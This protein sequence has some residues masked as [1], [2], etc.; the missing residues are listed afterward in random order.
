M[1]AARPASVAVV[2]RP[3][4][5]IAALQFARIAQVAVRQMHAAHPIDEGAQIRQDAPIEHAGDRIAQGRVT[6]RAEV[7]RARVA[8][9][10]AVERGILAT[11]AKGRLEVLR[12]LLAPL[13]RQALGELPLA[14]GTETVAPACAGV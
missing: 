4:A 2:L 5:C 8:A 3:R 11:D 13:A 7:V 6:V 9:R 1:R 14:V 10:L 12:V